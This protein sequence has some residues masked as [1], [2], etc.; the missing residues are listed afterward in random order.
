VSPKKF[1]VYN[2]SNSTQLICSNHFQSDAYAG[3]KK[4][5]KH[6]E[7]SHSQYRYKRMEELLNQQSKIT[8]QIAVDILRNKEGLNNKKIG[9]GN[10]KAITQLLAHHAIV[11]KPE[12]GLVW[13]SSNPYQ[14]GEFVAYDLNDIF[15]TPRKQY[16]SNTNLTIEK[17][18][19]QF[20]KAYQNY[21]TYRALRA[22]VL[23]SIKN[24][25]DVN[26]SNISK[27][28]AT[29]PEY[30]ESY[31]IVGEYYY[32]KGYLIAAL[33]AFEKAK[34][35]EITTIPDKRKIDLYIKKLKRK[36]EL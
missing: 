25:E 36:L 13:V 17:D 7:E 34:A 18:D 24:N 1:G 33:N 26:P 35:K 12:Q 15:N 3:D 11:F 9:Y 27:L 30:C 21:E 19:F 32:K 4:N 14:L 22:Q 23:G 5:E 16:L 20:S 28:Q 31:F 29:N 2:V 10:E 8:P 6:I